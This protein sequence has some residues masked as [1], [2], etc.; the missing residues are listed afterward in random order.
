[1]SWLLENWFGNK[2]SLE[3]VREDV[4]EYLQT[5]SY[6][7]ISGLEKPEES[8][9]RIAPA[10]LEMNLFGP[11]SGR[12]DEMDMDLLRFIHDQLPPI[13]R[14]EIGVMPF[15]TNALDEGYLVL[16][17]I[18]N[19]TERDVFMER[20]PLV[21][22]TVDGEV[23]ARKTF[24]MI[25]F[26]GLADMSSRPYD[27]FFRWDEFI[28]VPEQE[29]LLLLSVDHEK[30]QQ[31]KRAEE[32][33]EVKNGLTAEEESLFQAEAAK[34]PAAGRVDLHVVGITNVEEGGI[35]VIVALGNGLGARVEITEVPIIV[36]DKAGNLVARVNYGLRNLWVEAGQ[37]RLY[38]FYIPED[39]LQ[40]E[41]VDAHQCTAYIPEASEDGFIPQEPAPKGLVQ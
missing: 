10:D 1:M 36:Q 20:L 22:T 14:D 21:L 2:E 18:R 15:F 23:V 3:Q 29:V 4:Q 32:L 12:L 38:G 40:Q 39:S 6:V 17:F 19:A 8:S 26:G 7:G 41:K 28:K 5:E 16:A 31:S 9:N 37:N 35:K 11:W 24:D 27:F 33:L 30:Q 13:V 25:Q 34:A